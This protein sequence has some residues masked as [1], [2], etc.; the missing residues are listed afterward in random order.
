MR[1]SHAALAELQN[2]PVPKKAPQP[3]DEMG[4]NEEIDVSTES[5]KQQ[6]LFVSKKSLKQGKSSSLP[7]RN[8]AEARMQELAG[9]P[10]PCYHGIEH[11]ASGQY[12]SRR[13]LGT[14][15]LSFQ[16]MAA[17]SPK[18]LCRTIFF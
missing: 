14:I 16:S 1:K 6:L 4:F 8:T 5:I 17:R 12:L 18:A 11:A 7:G 10:G 3:R 15:V 2:L 13:L 9:V